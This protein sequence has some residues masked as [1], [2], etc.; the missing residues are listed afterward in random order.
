MSLYFWEKELDAR[1]VAICFCSVLGWSLAYLPF[2]Y[3]RHLT[4]SFAVLF[5]FSIGFPVY[6]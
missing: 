3:P 6:L 4:Y 2:R 5:S 1:E